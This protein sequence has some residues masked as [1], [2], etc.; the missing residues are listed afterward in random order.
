MPKQKRG[1]A[2]KK[3]WNQ[4][5]KDKTGKN[6]NRGLPGPYIQ[7]YGD[8]SVRTL[9][10][11]NAWSEFYSSAAGKARATKLAARYAKRMARQDQNL[12]I[13]ANFGDTI[14][15]NTNLDAVRIANAQAEAAA[16]RK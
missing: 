7:K 5:K 11:G 13:P 3:K 10:S 9:I 16:S 1:N 14:K 15:Q 4:K 6:P 8:E 2:T 12:A